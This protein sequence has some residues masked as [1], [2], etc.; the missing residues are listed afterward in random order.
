MYLGQSS[1]SFNTFWQYIRKDGVSLI[2]FNKIMRQGK[3]F[4]HELPLKWKCHAGT[5]SKQ[6]IDFINNISGLCKEYGIV[7]QHNMQNLCQP[8]GMAER[9]INSW[10]ACFQLLHELHNAWLELNFELKYTFEVQS[11]GQAN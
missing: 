5:C 8:F 6:R 11:S 9:R 3:S 2:H 10:M 7:Y 1:F 4:S